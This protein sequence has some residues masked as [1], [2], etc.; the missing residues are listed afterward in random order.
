MRN[1]MFS[2]RDCGREDGQIYS[3]V[4]ATVIAA[5]YLQVALTAWLIYR[6]LSVSVSLGFAY[7]LP[8][9]SGVRAGLRHESVLR[10]H[11]RTLCP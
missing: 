7:H 2:S 4:V 1:R 11:E 3:L 8:T 10:E 6:G 5:L 9:G